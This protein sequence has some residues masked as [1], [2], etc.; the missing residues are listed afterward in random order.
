MPNDD[1]YNETEE[2]EKAYDP[3]TQTVALEGEFG[4]DVLEKIVAF[5]KSRNG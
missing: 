4:V 1:N 3:D 5:L 2:M